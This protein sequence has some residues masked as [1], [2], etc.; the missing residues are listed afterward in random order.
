MTMQVIRRT[1]HSNFYKLNKRHAVATHAHGPSSKGLHNPSAYSQKRPEEFGMDWKSRG[2]I[3]LPS[4]FTIGETWAG[5]RKSWLG[6]KVAK[7][8]GDR[9]LM[10]KYAHSIRK[11]QADMGISETIFDDDLL[12]ED[13]IKQIEMQ[14]NILNASYDAVRK[15]KVEE[16]NRELQQEERVPDY[17]AIMHDARNE[18]PEAPLPR[19][20]IFVTYKENENSCPVPIEPAC[21]VMHDTPVKKRKSCPYVPPIETVMHDYKKEE[22]RR[23]EKVRQVKSCFIKIKA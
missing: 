18:L 21:E 1:G 2:Q 23:K 4:G 20:E 13:A 6:F 3:E 8:N 5:I 7:D 15:N 9:A 22:K 14:M 16:F 11:M 19:E 12:S 10:S 17:E